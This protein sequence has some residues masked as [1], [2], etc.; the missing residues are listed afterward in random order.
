MP[1][2]HTVVRALVLGA[3]ALTLVHAQ[4]LSDSQ[5]QKVKANLASSAQH[6]CV[7]LLPCCMTA[8]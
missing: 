8:C 7:H 6:R 2:V 3:G 4:T 5:V 1:G